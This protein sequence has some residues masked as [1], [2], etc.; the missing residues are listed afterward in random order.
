MGAENAAVTR[1]RA[2]QGMT[3]GAFMEEDAGV[4]W[5][6]E[7][8]LVATRGTPQHG[9]QDDRRHALPDFTKWIP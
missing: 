9:L 3:A 7:R 4:G 6:H 5:H 8:F 2:E 1:I